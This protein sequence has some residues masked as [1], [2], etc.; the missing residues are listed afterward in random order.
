MQRKSFI[1]HVL[2]VDHKYSDELAIQKEHQSYNF[3][4]LPDFQNALNLINTNFIPKVIVCNIDL[5]CN[6]FTGLSF[7]SNIRCNDSWSSIPI[8]ALSGQSHSDVILE[9]LKRG[10]I[11]FVKC[12]YQP[13]E[14]FKRIQHAS[15]INRPQY[16]QQPQK[17]DN[18]NSQLKELR[19][20]YVETMKYA[21]LY[22]ETCTQKTKIDLAEASGL[23]SV[24]LDKNGSYRTRTLDRYLK[25]E[26]LPKNP[27][28]KQI[29]LTA[30]YVLNHCQ[31]QSMIQQKLK[32]CFFKLL[33]TEEMSSE[34]FIFLK[35]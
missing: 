8:I 14:L 34:D 29:L 12:P 5:Q 16:C 1:N 10:A 3:I 25:E 31:K 17:I 30:N 6:S 11:D 33:E 9:S 35:N 32:H 26:S 23:W 24:Y 13:V 15:N 27:K 22:W 4:I 18:K 19:K 7:I 21:V 2:I 28:V 20:M